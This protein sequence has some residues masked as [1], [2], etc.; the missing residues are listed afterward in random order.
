MNKQCAPFF[1]VCCPAFESRWLR[2]ELAQAE[3][4]RRHVI[5]AA[6]HP[7]SPQAARRTHLAW[8]WRELSAVLVASPAVA[9]V[10]AGHDHVGGYACHDGIHWLTLPAML[11]GEACFAASNHW[12]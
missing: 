1:D 3:S 10:L 11:E 2:G 5:V 7:I 12:V 9:L 8:N 4:E 6:H